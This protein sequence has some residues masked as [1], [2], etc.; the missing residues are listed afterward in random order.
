MKEGMKEGKKVVKKR[1]LRQK[2]NLHC[3]GPFLLPVVPPL[4]LCKGVIGRE[5]KGDMREDEV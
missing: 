1:V 5:K 4:S 3:S 2:E